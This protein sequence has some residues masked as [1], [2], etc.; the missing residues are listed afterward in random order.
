MSA[1]NELNCGRLVQEVS[2]KNFSILLRVLSCDILMKK[3]A[4]FCHCLKSLPEVE[5]KCVV[6]IGKGNLRTV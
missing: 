2:E 3:V 6:L 1:E 4:A 5:E